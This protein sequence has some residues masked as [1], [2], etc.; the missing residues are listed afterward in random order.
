[1]LNNILDIESMRELKDK[2]KEITQKLPQRN[3]QVKILEV[4]LREMADRMRRF[5]IAPRR[6]YMRRKR[7]GEGNIQKDNGLKTSRTD[8]RH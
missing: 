7:M 8:E 3:W 6:S 2:S 4:K 1:M 5:N